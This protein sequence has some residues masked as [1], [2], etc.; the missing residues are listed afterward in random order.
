MNPPTRKR[1]RETIGNLAILLAVI[2][3]FFLSPKAG[4]SGTTH[5]G[6]SNSTLYL[7]VVFGQPSE[8]YIPAGVFQM[9]CKPQQNGGY[10]C[11]G[12]ELPLH[13][14]Y[15][16][17]YYI[18]RTEVTTAEYASCVA[19]GGCTE[20]SSFSSNLRANYYGNPIYADFP[21][22]N[23]DWF[24]AEAYC[25]WAGGRL[26]TEA[27]WEK[28]ARGAGDTRPF[29]WGDPKPSCIEANARIEKTYCVGDT[30]AVGS[31][32]PA[33]DSPYGVQDMV[34]NVYEYVNDWY[35]GSYYGSSPASNPPGPSSGSFKVRRGGAYGT[36]G[37]SL[38]VVARFTASP[39][40][41]VNYIGIRCAYSP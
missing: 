21:V 41:S 22:I 27:E 17:A 3:P 40:M 10:G 37:N 7:P 32:S 6:P 20:P 36:W 29:P 13:T 15:L 11:I 9:G 26:P 28:A 30:S 23:I 24:Q 39:T 1:K 12:N 25:Q 2:L 4:W 5:S 38:R 8:V 19:A 14:V 33:G 31:F 35:S 16:D 18:D 34:G